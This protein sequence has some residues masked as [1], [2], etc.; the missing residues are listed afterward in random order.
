MDPDTMKPKID[1]ESAPVRPWALEAYR[2]AAGEHRWRMR[3]ANGEIVADC[4]EGYTRAVDRDAAM[5]RLVEAG[6]RGLVCR[7]QE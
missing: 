6:R 2:D 7:F 1:P 5:Q 3:A 4:G